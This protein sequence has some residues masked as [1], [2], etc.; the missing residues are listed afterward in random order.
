MRIEDYRSSA[1]L[2]S[3]TFRVDLPVLL[4]DSEII[5]LPLSRRRDCAASIRTNAA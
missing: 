4:L 5:S 2:V 1:S 3:P